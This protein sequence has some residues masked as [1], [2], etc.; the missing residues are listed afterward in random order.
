L[1][2]NYLTTDAKKNSER[3]NLAALNARTRLASLVQEEGYKA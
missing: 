1:K 3:H 2:K